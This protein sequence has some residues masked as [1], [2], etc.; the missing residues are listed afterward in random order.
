MHQIRKNSDLRKRTHVFKYFKLLKHF[1]MQM[2]QGLDLLNCL[3]ESKE[4]EG[5]GDST[6]NKR[7]IK[8]S[9][10]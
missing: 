9:V 10:N 7:L 8:C 3:K 2:Y 1:K 6:V 5:E 4:G